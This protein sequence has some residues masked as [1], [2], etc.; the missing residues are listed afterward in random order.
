M[1]FRKPFKKED[2]NFL[3]VSVKTKS[4][5]SSSVYVVEKGSIE[6]F[7]QAHLNSDTIILIDSVET[8]IKSED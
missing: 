2:I 7:I 5:Q 6:S 3:L 1:E 4:D 8:F